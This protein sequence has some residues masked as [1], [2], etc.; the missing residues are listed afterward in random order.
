MKNGKLF[1]QFQAKHQHTHTHTHTTVLSFPQLEIAEVVAV[2]S[3]HTLLRRTSDDAP[4]LTVM[5]MS[6]GE[7]YFR[8]M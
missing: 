7:L 3:K 4:S 2:F 5:E 6:L 8:I 1:I